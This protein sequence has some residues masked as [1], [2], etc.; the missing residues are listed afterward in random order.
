MLLLV[1]LSSVVLDLNLD[2]TSYLA[3]TYKILNT[4]QSLY[5]RTLLH[6]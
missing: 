6:I 5:L 2:L 4:Y 1:S 3:L